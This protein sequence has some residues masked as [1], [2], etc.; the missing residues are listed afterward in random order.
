MKT[1]KKRILCIA[2]AAVLLCSLAAF[3][4]C[5][6]KGGPSAENTTADTSADTTQGQEAS[7]P[8]EP[9][10]EIVPVTDDAG[11]TVTEDGGA[12]VTEIRTLP[13]QTTPADEKQEPQPTADAP[14]PGD[15]GTVSASR[16][17]DGAAVS[18]TTDKA[19]PLK[20][21]DSLTL[22]VRLSDAKLLACFT[23]HVNYDPACLKVKEAYETH[24]SELSGMMKEGD[25]RVTY[26]GF[27]M[28]TTN[29]EDAAIFTVEFEV[30]KDPAGATSTVITTEIGQY[31]VGTDASGAQTSDLTGQ[32]E[33]IE[34]TVAL[35]G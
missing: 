3:E 21:G 19:G 28:K 24:E 22:T 9:E 30:A 11:E 6:K 33:A 17:K 29:V 20:A 14:A 27:V 5:G 32:F 12:A 4:A 31:L 26:G 23:A 2:L 8:A 16:A 35:Q 34:N 7:V 15:A 13:A 25:A 10:T 1:K 18:V